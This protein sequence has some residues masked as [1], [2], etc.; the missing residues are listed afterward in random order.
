MPGADGM[1]RMQTLMQR[2]R[3]DPPRQIAGSPVV[4]RLDY[5]SGVATSADGAQSPITGPRGDVLVYQSDDRGNRVAVRPSGT[6]PKI[7]FY[8]F[9]VE[10]PDDDLD[11]AKVRASARICSALA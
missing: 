1:A 8:L 4:R 3:D 7:K 2:L 9:A 6:E 5:R 10:E 11:A